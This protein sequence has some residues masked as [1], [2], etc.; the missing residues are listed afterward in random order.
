MPCWL[1][2]QKIAIL[3]L[4]AIPSDMGGDSST[5]KHRL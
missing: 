5:R 4:S 1:Q 3:D 2:T